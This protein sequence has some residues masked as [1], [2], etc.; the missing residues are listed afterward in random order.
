MNSRAKNFALANEN[1]PAVY[2]SVDAGKVTYRLAD[3]K[4]F[5]LSAQDARQVTPRWVYLERDWHKPALD[6]FDREQ[7]KTL[8]RVEAE[9]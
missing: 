1:S 3:G 6:A 8:R 9:L 7:A 4:V 5:R 2:C